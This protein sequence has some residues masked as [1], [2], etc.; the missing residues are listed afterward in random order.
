MVKITPKRSSPVMMMMMTTI[1]LDEC[2]WNRYHHKR[3]SEHDISNKFLQSLCHLS[4]GNDFLLFCDKKHQKKSMQFLF[5]LYLFCV[6][7]LWTR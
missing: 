3:T 4:E 6:C 5:V 1:I 7:S 2:N